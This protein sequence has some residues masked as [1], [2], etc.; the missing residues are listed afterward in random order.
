MR[1]RRPVVVVDG[2]S[3]SGKSSTARGVAQRLGLRYLDT[4]AM[5]RAV[6]WWLLHH[7]VDVDDPAAVTRAMPGIVVDVTTDPTRPRV[8]VNGQDVTEDIR[9]RAVTNAVSA[10]SAV[11]AVREQLVAVQ[12]HVLAGGGVVAEGRDLGTVVVPD[13]DLKLFLT[14]DSEARAHRRQAELSTG[15]SAEVSVADTQRELLTRDRRD[16]TRELSPLTMADDAVLLDST[17]LTLEEVVDRIVSLVQVLEADVAPG[18][19]GAGGNNHAAGAKRGDASTIASP[20]T[21]P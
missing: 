14:A 21:T 15:P 2:P 10:V 11:P 8:A 19:D 20:G 5:Y 9:E 16:S 6:T 17:H 4:G 13:A 3:G 1:E 18:H 12:Q 7:D